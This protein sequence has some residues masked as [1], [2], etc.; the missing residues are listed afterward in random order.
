MNTEDNLAQEQ[1]WLAPSP[2]AAGYVLAVQSNENVLLRS[3]SY[4]FKS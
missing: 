2:S 4:R 1:S 3:V